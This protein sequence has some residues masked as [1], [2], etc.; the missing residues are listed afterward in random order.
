MQ[1]YYWCFERRVSLKAS[2][3][4]ERNKLFFAVKK[5]EGKYCLKLA[6]LLKEI[7]I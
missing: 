4:L 3:L 2:F 6:I 7:Y 1:S 5:K